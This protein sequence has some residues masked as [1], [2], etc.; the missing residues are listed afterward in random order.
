METWEKKDLP[1]AIA[2]PFDSVEL[3]YLETQYVFDLVDES[4][5]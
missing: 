4:A 3:I 2:A 1:R 5:R